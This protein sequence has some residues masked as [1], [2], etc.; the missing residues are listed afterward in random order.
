MC[1]ELITSTYI[2]TPLTDK[3]STLKTHTSTCSI[4]LFTARCSARKYELCRGK[5]SVCL[6][7]TR[8]NF[9]QT[10]KHT[11]KLF[12][13]SGIGSHTI[14]VL[15]YQKVGN[16]PTRP[17]PPYRGRRMQG[18]WKNRDFRPISRFISEMTQDRSI[19]RNANR[20]SYVIC[21]MVLFL[22]TLNDLAK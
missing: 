17:P 22:M 9:V 5:M 4:L 15:S 20:N 19:V 7:V 8:R 1:L 6:S 14:P 21:W 12:S 16:I 3:M 13:P 2:H 18:V 10:A 11:I